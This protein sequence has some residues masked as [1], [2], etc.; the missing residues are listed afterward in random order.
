MPSSGRPSGPSEC[1]VRLSA[2]PVTGRCA[3]RWAALIAA[4][5]CGPTEPVDRPVIQ[6]ER[7]QRDLDAGVLGVRVRAGGRSENARR[8]PHSEKHPKAHSRT[9]F[10]LAAAA[11]CTRRR[12][13]GM[14]DLLLAWFAANERDLPW[15]RTRDPYAILV[16]EVMLQQTQVER[17]VPRYLAW[18]ERWPTVEALAAAATADV[19]REWQGLGYNRRAL[20]LHRA[21]ARDQRARLA[22]RPDRTAGR[23]RVH[24]GGDPQ[25]RVRRRRAAGRHERA[26]RAGA[27][28]PSR[29]ARAA[30]RR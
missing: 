12:L 22:E 3:R 17:V 6:T 2:S 25:L 8:D 23:R 14:D 20:N 21:A 11:S 9:C 28:R 27:D 13:A 10:G 30:R 29:S 24:R 5:V 16:S 4:T 15:R 19:L 7:A 18:L 1:R 26:P